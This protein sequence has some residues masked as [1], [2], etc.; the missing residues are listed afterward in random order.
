MYSLGKKLSLNELSEILEINNHTDNYFFERLVF[1]SRV[2]KKGDLFIPLK[3]S[4]HDGE[5][6]VT[7]VV[8]QGASALT[9]QNICGPTLKV[10]NIYE[11]LL[12]ICKYKISLFKPKIIFI[13]GSYGKTTIKDMLKTALGSRCHASKE[14]E[15]NEFGIPFTILSMPSD[16]QYL[17]VECGAR[18]TGDFD[19]ISSILFCDLFILTAITE[20]HLST[21]GTIENIEKTK[22]KLRECLLQKSNFID[23]REVNKNNILETNKEIVRQALTLL[24]FQIDINKITFDSSA[25]RGNIIYRHNGEIIDQTYN[26]HPDTVLATAL[27][28]DPEKTILILGDMAELGDDEHDIHLKTLSRLSKYEIFFTGLIY[29][30]IKDSLDNKNHV[31]FNNEDDFPIKYLTKQLKARKKIYFKGSRSSKMERYLK[32]LL[33]D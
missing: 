20:N 32:I 30:E 18:K 33:D 1:D 4:I 11:S 23:G 25:G 5:K 17:V 13:T 16:S 2:A 29:K 27:E 3:G 31:Y 22:M 6:F 10:E 14:N 8:E 9:I 21:F 19:L 12:K 26:A 28:E 15:N 7:D 24:S